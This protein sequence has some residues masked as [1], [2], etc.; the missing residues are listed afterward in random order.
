MEKSE[1]YQLLEQQAAA[2]L[3]DEHDLIASMS[4]LAALLFSGLPNVSYAGFYRYQNGELILGPFQGP[5]ACM[6]IPLGRGVC[7]TAAQ[8]QKT[9]IV[10]D[11][12]KFS[13]HIACDA[14][15]NSEIVVP[16]IKN[17]QLLAV[18]DIDS[19]D[20]NNFDQIDA[21]YLKKIIQLV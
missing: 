18:L 7:G 21:K 20:F 9:Q 17:E 14:D 5:V 1:N 8:T 11:V 19:H 16:L 2:L 15:T 3:K 12:H 6:H 13:G 10:P 4:N